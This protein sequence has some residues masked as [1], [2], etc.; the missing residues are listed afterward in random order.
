M[1]PLFLFFICHKCF[2]IIIIIITFTDA[3]NNWE[4]TV[5]VVRIISV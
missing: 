1:P 2:I 3:L 4:Y 5:W